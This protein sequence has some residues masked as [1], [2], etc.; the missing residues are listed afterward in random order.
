[1]LE[2][3][4]GR[5]GVAVWQGLLR[6]ASSSNFCAL[7]IAGM[8]DLFDHDTAMLSKAGWGYSTVRRPLRAMSA[9]Q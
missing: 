1:M 2:E 4:E 5:K 8:P 7:G 9:T 3:R 6:R